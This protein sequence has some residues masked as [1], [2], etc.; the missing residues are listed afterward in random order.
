MTSYRAKRPLYIW[1]KLCVE[2][3]D[4]PRF[5]HFF[6]LSCILSAALLCYIFCTRKAKYWRWRRRN[7]AD[8]HIWVFQ[9]QYT[10]GTW[11]TALSGSYSMG[12]AL[13]CVCLGSWDATSKNCVHASVTFPPPPSWSKKVTHQKTNT[14]FRSTFVTSHKKWLVHIRCF[15]FFS[16]FILYKK[17]IEITFS[18]LISNPSPFEASDATFLVVLHRG[19]SSD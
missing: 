8:V 3:V 19:Q 11:D 15:F 16:L 12:I 17:S 14:S 2:V 13:F 7:P 10:V 1:Q 9:L 18:A 6:F 5:T 4:S